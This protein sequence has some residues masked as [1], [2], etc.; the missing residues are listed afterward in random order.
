MHHSC[1]IIFVKRDGGWKW[2]PVDEKA[3]PLG[4]ASAE[5]YALFYECVA[6]ARSRGFRPNVKC[7]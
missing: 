6:A 2:R 1:E 5:T 7:L 3:R 4:E